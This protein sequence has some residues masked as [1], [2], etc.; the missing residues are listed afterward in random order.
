MTIKTEGVNTNGCGRDGYAY[1][2]VYQLV[3]CYG[4]VDGLG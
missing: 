1:S 2:A 4:G 3:F